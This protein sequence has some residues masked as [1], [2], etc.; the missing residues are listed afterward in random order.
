MTNDD[1][2]ELDTPAPLRRLRKRSAS[3]SDRAHAANAE[4]QPKRSLYD[5]LRGGPQDADRK[6]RRKLDAREFV[7]G[8]AEESD[9]EGRGWSLNRK[10]ANDGEED[11]DEDMDKPVE[12][13][14]NDEA[15]DDETLAEHLVREKH[16]SVIHADRARKMQ[17]LML[18]L[19]R[20][21]RRLTEGQRRRLMPLLKGEGARGEEMETS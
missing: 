2:A 19:G 16:K 6:K 5:V 14:V 7:V 3:P 9:D 13:L 10:P 1:D 20:P 11:D 17:I 8:E 12:N 18:D 4:V 21:R 15:M